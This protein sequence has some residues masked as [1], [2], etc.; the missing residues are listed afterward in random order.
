MSDLGHKFLAAAL[1]RDGAKALRKA[2]ERE[3]QL[4]EVLIPR[5][6]VGWLNFTAENEYEGTI[7]GVENSYVQ[8]AKSEDGFD[9]SI[10]LE[11][12]TY[13]FEKSSVYH[14][15]ACIA[16]GLGLEPSSLDADVRDAVLVKLGKSIDTLTKAQVLMQELRSPKAAKVTRMTTHGHYHIEHNG[17]ADRPYSVVHTR[18]G[19]PVQQGIAS[20]ADA[21]PIANWHQNRYQGTFNPP[22][23]KR[24]LDP[25]AGYQISHEHHD[26]GDE[27]LTAVTAHLGGQRVGAALYSHKGGKLMPET[28][29]VDPDHRR[30]GLGTALQNHAKQVTG[31][32]VVR[33]HDETPNGRAFHDATVQKVELPGKAHLPTPQQGP[34][35]PTAPMKQPA[36]A[37]AK[38]A[39]KLPSLA[40]GKSEADQACDMCGGHQF[41]GN[42]FRGCICFRELSKSVTTTAYGDG[43]VLTFKPTMDRESVQALMKAFRSKNG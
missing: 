8:F 33:S 24:V 23:A 30:K 34:I 32:E 20:L 6:I 36:N 16:M 13:S 19:S 26:L 9:G 29:Q 18:T 39:K 12:G 25:S 10:S 27:F 21:Q 22:L 3:P 31:K 2:V 17:T 15:A 11:S 4:A 40:V 28:I 7:P 35:G 37:V 42:K 38:P 41:E 14:L 43:Y 1:G 5:A